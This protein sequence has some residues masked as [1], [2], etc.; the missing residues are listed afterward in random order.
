MS[1]TPDARPVPGEALEGRAVL[2]TGSGRGLGAAVARAAGLRSAKVMV[3]CRQ[4]GKAAQAVADEVRRS[5][6]EALACRADVT[7]YVQAQELVERTIAA[8]GR[9]DVLVNTVGVFAWKPVADVEPGEW[10]AMMASNLDAVYHMCRLALPAMR[11]RH[12]GR[13]INIG[14]VGAE[15]TLAPPTMAGYSAAKAA[16]VAFSKALAL[17]E[18]RCGITVNVVCPG[19]L[20]DGATGHDLGGVRVPVG[21]AG[22]VD[23]VVRSILFFCSPAADFLT[24]QVL[25][26]AGGWRL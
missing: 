1:A 17:E 2:V 16:V 8:F 18:A 21:R 5:G 13:I 12:W 10:R 14:A 25:A 4:D 24:G 20:G 11:Q 6:G 15:R 19:V 22:S 7:D 9:L 3:N 26:V 23:D